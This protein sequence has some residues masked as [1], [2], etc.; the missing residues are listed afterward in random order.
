MSRLQFAHIPGMGPAG[1]TCRVCRH[2][3]TD[4][5]KERVC[6]KAAELS[7]KRL[8]DLTPV[9]GGTCACKYWEERSET[10]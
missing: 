8:E 10:P 5:H 9:S 6:A 7:G 4:S 2:W 3:N 1:K